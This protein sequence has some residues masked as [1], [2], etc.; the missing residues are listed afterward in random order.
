[1]VA[2]VDAM[3]YSYE[4]WGDFIDFFDP[5]REIVYDSFRSDG[6]D[7]GFH[8]GGGLRVFVSDDVAIVGEARYYWSKTQMDDDFSRNEIDLGG[9]AATVG[10]HVRF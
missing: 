10:V 4:E 5:D 2:G 6:V 1:V 9:L 7:F 3:V 8:L